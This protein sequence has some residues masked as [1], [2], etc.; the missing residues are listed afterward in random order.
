MIIKTKYK[1]FNT[2]GWTE[3]HIRR[4]VSKFVCVMN[5]TD[6]R[7]EHLKEFN[8]E[9]EANDFAENL[10]NVIANKDVKIYTLSE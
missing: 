2:D 6:G 8:S 5:F 10:M 3:L 4:A 1:Y 9:T 7:V